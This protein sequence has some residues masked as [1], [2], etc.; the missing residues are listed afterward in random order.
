M[1]SRL[2]KT[3][4]V[5]FLD[6]TCLITNGKTPHNTGAFPHILLSVYNKVNT[7]AQRDSSAN[8]PQH[9]SRPRSHATKAHICVH[10]VADRPRSQQRLL[11]LHLLARHICPL[12]RSM[13]Q[14][15]SPHT[16]TRTRTSTSGSLSHNRHPVACCPCCWC[17]TAV[18][19]HRLNPD[20]QI[21]SGLLHAQSVNKRRSRRRHPGAP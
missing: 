3:A 19:A 6:L 9:S 10:H 15:P 13:Q 8:R 1:S 7:T 5:R 17:D 18:V 21:R 11:H 16:H 20:R 14:T 2:H 12:Q 4:C